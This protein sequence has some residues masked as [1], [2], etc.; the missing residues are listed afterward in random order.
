LSK[1]F[2]T[3]GKDSE[4]LGQKFQGLVKKAV[5]PATAALAGLAFQANKSVQAAASMDE[6]ISK[7]NVLFGDVTDTIL[8]F[9]ETTARSFGISQKATLDAAGTFAIFGKSAGL[10]GDDLATFSIDFVKLA[11]DFASFFNTSP[12][13]AIVAIGAALRGESEPIRRFGV[14]LNEATLR[15]EAFRLG[16]I[17]TTKDALTPQQRVLAA[18]AAIFRQSTDA[19]GDA[20]RTA[21]SFANRQKQ[22]TAQMADFNVQVGQILLPIFERLLPLL[23]RFADWASRNPELVTKVAAAVGVLS[24]AIVGLNFALSANPITLY[25]LG[26][27]ALGAA[28]YT[29]WQRSEAARN[30]MKALLVL[31]VPAQGLTFVLVA[32]VRNLG[33]AFRA[34]WNQMQRPLNALKSFAG[35]ALRGLLGGGLLGPATGIIGGAIGGLRN[36]VPF[37]GSGGVVSGP[38]LS[39]IGES[40]P[41]AVVPLDRAGEFGMGGGGDTYVTINV[42]GADP[43]AVVQA[44]RKY[45]ANTGPIPIRITG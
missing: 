40:G 26:T 3:V 8:Q 31:F 13:E 45:L 29:L 24:A 30:V 17:K 43:N 1:A 10:A 5:V 33:D 22:L 18:R 15:E 32:A 6:A 42:Q 16:L 14:L 34:L 27:I 2:R 41:E 21:D 23:Q 19:Q 39:V 25:T 37:L 7:T 38:T 28:L 36:I 4:T 11:G 44:L 35:G 20:A 9:S 12:D